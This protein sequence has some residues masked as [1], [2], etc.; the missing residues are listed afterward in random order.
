MQTKMILLLRGGM[1]RRG[2]GFFGS[3]GGF[4]PLPIRLYNVPCTVWH[5]DPACVTRIVVRVAGFEHSTAASTIWCVTKQQPL[6][7]IL[8]SNLL[9]FTIAKEYTV[10]SRIKFLKNELVL[11]SHSLVKTQK[12]LQPV[13]LCYF[14]NRWNSHLV[15]YTKYVCHPTFILNV[16]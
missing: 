9:L 7:Q 8:I 5:R 4:P 16:L 14:E 1:W 10:H 11:L 2:R 12:Y 6:L 15:M 3:G 13:I